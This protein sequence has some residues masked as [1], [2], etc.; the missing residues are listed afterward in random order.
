MR[1]ELEEVKSLEN[2]L[3]IHLNEE[4]QMDVEI[5]LLW[6]QEYQKR[7]AAQQVAYKALQLAGRQQLRHELRAIHTRLFG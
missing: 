7:L 1:P 4:E 2:Y 3:N 5:R 6:D